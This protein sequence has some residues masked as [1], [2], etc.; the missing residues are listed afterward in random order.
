MPLDTYELRKAKPTFGWRTTMRQ[1]YSSAGPRRVLSGHLRGTVH[2]Q[3]RFMTIVNMRRLGEKTKGD[4]FGALANASQF[5]INCV[6]ALSTVGLLAMIAGREEVR[7]GEDDSVVTA[8]RGV[9]SLSTALLLWSI[10]RLYSVDWL[11]T[12]LIHG[13]SEQNFPWSTSHTLCW[14]LET[15][16][17]AVH[18]PPYVDVQVNM[19]LAGTSKVVRN[20]W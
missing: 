6:V 4:E 17:C 15:L 1:L 16:L 7:A 10:H 11:L 12:N 2:G 9:Q 8:L 13:V 5:W 14:A 18:E 19:A 20:P 3:D